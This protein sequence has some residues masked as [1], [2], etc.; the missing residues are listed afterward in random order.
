MAGPEYVFTLAPSSMF[1]DRMKDMPNSNLTDIK[2]GYVAVMGRPNVGKSTLINALLGQKIAAVSPRPQ[3]TRKRQ[4]GILTTQVGQIIFTDTPGIHHPHHKLGESMNTEA[5]EALEACDLILFVVDAGD[6]PTDE[7]RLLASIL[8]ELHRPGD[9]LIVI[10]KIDLLDVPQLEKRLIEFQ[11]LLPEAQLLTAS[12]ERG[13]HL[14]ELTETLFEKLPAGPLYYPEGQVTDLYEREIAADL[15]REAA[16]IHLRDE[17]PHG[18]A[19]RIDE[20]TERGDHGAYIAATMFVEKESHKPIVIGK[21]G[22][23]IKLLGASAR[24]KIEEM[25][26]RKVYLE[27]RVKVRPN[28]RNDEK[29]LSRFG[30]SDRSG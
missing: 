7:D 8:G 16:L 12:A 14:S 25:S 19:V 17:V 29:T 30:Y 3:T 1:S 26:G 27:L 18:I 2:S 22:A 10:N 21:G 23:T 20:Y 24:Q 15:I 11:N 28:W 13:D 5:K 9:I 4:L 6:Q